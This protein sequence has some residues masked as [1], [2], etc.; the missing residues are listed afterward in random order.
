VRSAAEAESALAGG[1]ALIDVKEPERGPLGRADDEIVRAVVQAVAG[2]TPV[3]AALG[4]L[5]DQQEEPPPVP[6]GLDFVKW[7]LAGAGAGGGALDWR[8]MFLRRACEL[9]LAG[10]AVLVAYADAERA[11]A[12]PV[13]E[14]A[15]F[16]CW[17]PW[18]AADPVLLLDTFTKSP[19]PLS[20]T[21]RRPT[22]LDW[23]PLEEVVRLCGRCRAAGV[24]V[25][26]AGCLGAEEVRRLLPT[27]PDWFAVRGAACVGHDRLQTVSAD[28][29]RHLVDLCAGIR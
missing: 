18:P 21:S 3:S 9:N 1:A 23:L 17:R 25:A 20:A 13:A 8:Q 27:R 2:R 24:R 10:K 22:L 28:R 19:S 4:E 6:P 7:G 11:N 16:A 14:V 15:D 12:P 26:L 5:R 29:V